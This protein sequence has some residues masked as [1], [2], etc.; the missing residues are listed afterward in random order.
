MDIDQLAALMQ[1]EFERLHDEM[2]TREE[3][4]AVEGNVLRATEGRGTQLSQY[5]ARWNSDFGRLAD[6]VHDLGKHI[7]KLEASCSA[8]P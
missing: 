3:L 1:R 5:A 8:P 6:R 7:T 4:K 2:A